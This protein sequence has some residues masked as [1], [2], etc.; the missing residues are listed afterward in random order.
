MA[1]P[2]PAARRL[3]DCPPTALVIDDEA[4]IRGIIGRYLK[5]SGF[6]VLEAGDGVAGL[7]AVDADYT[8]VDVVLT[9][10]DLPRLDGFVVTELLTAYRPELPV[11]VVTGRAMGDPDRERLRDV[12]AVVE[13]PFTRT[14]LLAPLPSV[15]RAAHA[16]RQRARKA[17][18]GAAESRFIAGHMREVAVVMRMRSKELAA[19]VRALQRRD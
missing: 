2:L 8:F 19:R 9:D 3:T 17:R 1:T 18:A 12:L 11:I 13:K 10:L 5:P 15:L 6:A 7:Q 4:A 16:L 14:E